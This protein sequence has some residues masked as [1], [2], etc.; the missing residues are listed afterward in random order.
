MFFRI[1]YLIALIGIVGRDS[2][3]A[4][5]VEVTEPVGPGEERRMGGEG[6]G[7]VVSLVALLG[8]AV[9]AAIVILAVLSFAGQFANDIID[10]PA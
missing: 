10:P 9:L 3:S 2:G 1:L 6:F 5:R 4:P 8:V 7:N